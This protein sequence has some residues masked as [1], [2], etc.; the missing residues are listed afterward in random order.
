M[1]CFVTFPFSRILE[2]LSPC[3]ENFLHNS[4]IKENTSVEVTI[5][6]SRH[7]MNY[8]QVKHKFHDLDKSY[9]LTAR[10]IYS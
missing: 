7:L 3:E 9:N 8:F 6:E 10:M 5:H 1:E 2:K 4:K